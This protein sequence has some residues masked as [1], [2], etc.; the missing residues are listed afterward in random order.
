MQV[1]H[2]KRGRTG[3]MYVCK[4]HIFHVFVVV[5]C[6]MCYWRCIRCVWSTYVCLWVL[7][8]K[9]QSVVLVCVIHEATRQ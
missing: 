9:P 2:V 8:H 1:C 6:D 3:N 5:V 4:L 7:H